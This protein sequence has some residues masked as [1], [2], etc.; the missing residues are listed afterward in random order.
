MESFFF[1]FMRMRRMLLL[2]KNQNQL[3][4]IRSIDAG[5]DHRSKF[6]KPA[7]SVMMAYFKIQL[8]GNGNFGIG[9]KF[10][11]L[12]NYLI[13][14]ISGVY[15]A[16]VNRRRVFFDFFKCGEN[17]VF[18]HIIGQYLA[19]LARESKKHFGNIDTL[20][21]FYVATRK[22]SS[23]KLS[24]IGNFFLGKRRAL[25][26]YSAHFI[27]FLSRFKP[28]FQ[29]LGRRRIGIYLIFIR[30]DR[31]MLFKNH[32]SFRHGYFNRFSIAGLLVRGKS[33]G[34]F[35]ISLP[36]QIYLIE[37]KMIRRY[38]IFA[39]AM[40]NREF[41]ASVLHKT[42]NLVYIF[43]FSPAGRND[44]GLVGRGNFLQ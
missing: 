17:R 27:C 39:D 3:F 12:Q 23:L 32:R 5:Y 13:N 34:Y 25:A 41:L 42:D 22:Y 29:L 44:N 11:R 30:F 43:Q 15:F 6:V 18:T 33:D 19:S 4:G 14:L 20:A 7:D 16:R 21:F 28:S 26:D 9:Q 2:R 40:H 1:L 36:E 31:D 8:I 37:L 10:I 24:D 35:L 38:R